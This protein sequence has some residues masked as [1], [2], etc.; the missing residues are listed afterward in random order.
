MLRRVALVGTNVSGELS[1]SI[2]GATRIGEPIVVTLKK[3]LSSS[4]TSVLTRATRRNNPEDGMLHSRRHENLKFYTFVYFSAYI[5]TF[6]RWDSE[7]E[8]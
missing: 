5:L 7:V 3:T 6:C 8:L 2:I 4:E 1:A